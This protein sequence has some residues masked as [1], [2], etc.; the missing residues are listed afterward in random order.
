MDLTKLETILL[1]DA[2]NHYLKHQIGINTT[3]ALEYEDILKKIEDHLRLL[4]W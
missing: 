4:N 3:Q 2:V 1:R